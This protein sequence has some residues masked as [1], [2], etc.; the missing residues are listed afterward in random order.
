MSRVPCS[1]ERLMALMQHVRVLVLSF[2]LT[3]IVP[4]VAPPLG[5]QLMI[6]SCKGT[7]SPFVSIAAVCLQT[8]RSDVAF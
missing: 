7:F 4:L 2:N 3:G 1:G 5:A 6:L 8:Q